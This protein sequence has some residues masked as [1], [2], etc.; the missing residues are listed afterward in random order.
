MDIRLGSGH[1]RTS[2]AED[3]FW[4]GETGVTCLP[5]DGINQ[6]PRSDDVQSSLR[7]HTGSTACP[8]ICERG[9]RA[10]I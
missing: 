1:L 7:W 4:R 6:L 8:T 5:W 2:I 3:R 10:E 9:H